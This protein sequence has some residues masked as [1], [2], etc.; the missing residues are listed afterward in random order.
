MASQ[1]KRYV[2]NLK[3][4]MVGERRE[5]GRM[6]G[7][8]GGGRGGWREKRRGSREV[9]DFQIPYVTCFLGRPLLK[10]VQST[11][12]INS[13]LVKSEN[14]KS[15]R[16]FNGKKTLRSPAILILPKIDIF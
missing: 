6:Y 10:I 13:V 11:A 1:R 12:L 16:V 4:R 8:R 14:L 2:R 3:V 9:G 15:Q 7:G 5:E